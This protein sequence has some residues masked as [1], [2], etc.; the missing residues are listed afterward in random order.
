[1]LFSFT[2]PTLSQCAPAVRPFRSKA[3]Q[4]RGG[5]LNGVGKA[6]HDLLKH[7]SLKHTHKHTERHLLRTRIDWDAFVF[8]NNDQFE[9]TFFLV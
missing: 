3:K 6:E 1:M 5:T 2:Q 4:V 7:H 8:Y 9:D